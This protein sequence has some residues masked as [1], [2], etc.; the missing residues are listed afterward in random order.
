VIVLEVT[1]GLFSSGIKLVSD[2]EGVEMILIDAGLMS[3]ALDVLVVGESTI[4]V[5]LGVNVAGVG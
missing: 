4:E 5:G 1:E 2:V 3:L